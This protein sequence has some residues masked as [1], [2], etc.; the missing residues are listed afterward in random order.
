VVCVDSGGNDDLEE[1]KLY[2]VLPDSSAA[3]SGFLRIVDDSGEDYVYPGRLFVPLKV[4]ELLRSVLE[5][6]RR[7]ASPA[8]TLRK[9]AAADSRRPG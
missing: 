6:P 9:K 7:K 4:T 5:R 2:E 8:A 1:R 3:T